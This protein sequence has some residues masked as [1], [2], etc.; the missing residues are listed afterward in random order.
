MMRLSIAI[1]LLLAPAFAHAWPW[2]DDMANQISIKPQESVDLKNPGMTPYPKRSIPIPGTSSMIRD[3]EASEKQT[4]PIPADDKS[5]ALGKNLFE[6]YCAACHGV[7]GKGDGYV[8]AKLLLQPFD[9][10]AEQTIERSDGFIW[11]YMTFGG[12]IMPSYANDL[13]ATERWSVI[14]YVRKVLQNGQSAVADEPAA[15]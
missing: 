7:S 14:N 6:I 13:S 15:K 10:T 2:S 3:M 11:G 4:N 1:V 12:A 9:L 5:V 8:G